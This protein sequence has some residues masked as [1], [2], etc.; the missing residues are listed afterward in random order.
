[1]A[2]SRKGSTCFG[3]GGGSRVRRGFEGCRVGPCCS[4]WGCQV[5]ESSTREHEWAA[6]AGGAMTGARGRGGGN[7][8]PGQAPEQQGGGGGV[9]CVQPTLPL[10]AYT[11]G[12]IVTIDLR[13]EDSVSVRSSEARKTGVSGEGTKPKA[14][15]P[16]H[17][18]ARQEWCLSTCYADLRLGRASPKPKTYPTRS[19]AR[20]PG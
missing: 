8:P 7:V 20:K 9:Q 2:W 3:G 16:L 6:G 4:G 17:V 5:W 18:S 1:M 10:G 15:G 14:L 19:N 11:V 12:G 13:S